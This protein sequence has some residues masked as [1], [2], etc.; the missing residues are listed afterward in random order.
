MHSKLFVLS[1]KE[2]NILT[3]FNYLV[4]SHVPNSIKI[5][6]IRDFSS[7]VKIVLNVRNNIVDVYQA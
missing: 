5:V 2:T 6:K 3:V 4:V 1:V 7:K